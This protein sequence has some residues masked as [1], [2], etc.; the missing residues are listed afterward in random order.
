[1]AGINNTH[2]SANINFNFEITQSPSPNSL[3]TRFLHQIIANEC[4]S[5]SLFNIELFPNCIPRKLGI[6][7]KT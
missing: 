2:H 6:N 5:C 3:N 1:M 7:H 4:A